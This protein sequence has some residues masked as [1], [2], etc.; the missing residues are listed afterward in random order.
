MAGAGAAATS[1][2]GDG[3]PANADAPSKT[4]QKKSKEARP[5][6][7]AGLARVVVDAAAFPSQSR[8]GAALRKLV[9]GLIFGA[10]DAA[11]A[12]RR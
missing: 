1:S 5:G 12:R 10:V 11:R 2:R 3:C 4:K 9:K 6:V 7:L 8:D